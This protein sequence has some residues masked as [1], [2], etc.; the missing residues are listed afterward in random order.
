[1]AH[2]ITLTSDYNIR[3]LLYYCGV[4]VSFLLHKRYL[5][6]N[7]HLPRTASNFG[8]QGK[9]L[10]VL[11]RLSGDIYHEQLTKKVGFPLSQIKV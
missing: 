2:L 10:V 6:N 11:L 4:T 3:Q 5:M 8:S 9:E 1:M 7:D